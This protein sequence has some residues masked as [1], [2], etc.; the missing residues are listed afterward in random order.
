VYVI[1]VVM[2]K[3]RW[4]SSSKIAAP[5]LKG[6]ERRTGTGLEGKKPLKR[7]NRKQ[8]LTRVPQF[9]ARDE[10]VYRER[11]PKTDRLSE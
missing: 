11:L 3:P 7:A 2:P 5:S 1:V 8:N 9:G 6:R 10:K 4:A